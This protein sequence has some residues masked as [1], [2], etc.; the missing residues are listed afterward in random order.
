MVRTVINTL[1]FV[2]ILLSI[3]AIVKYRNN[4]K[5]EK[6]RAEIEANTVYIPSDTKATMDLTYT[7]RGV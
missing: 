3:K 2:A 7:E 5:E 4:V 6:L 1:L